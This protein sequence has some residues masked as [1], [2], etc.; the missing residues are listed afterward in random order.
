[1]TDPNQLAKEI[2]DLDPDL[3]GILI[4]L[5]FESKRTLVNRIQSWVSTNSANDQE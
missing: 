4:A 3:A 2:V 1:M 5:S